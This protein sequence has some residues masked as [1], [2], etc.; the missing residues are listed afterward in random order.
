MD[1]IRAFFEYGGR[2]VQMPVNP[3]EF[4][5]EGEVDNETIDL[6]N[7]G[8]SVLLGN[9]KLRVLDFESFFPRTSE[10]SYV[11]TKG[12]F[13]APQFY[14]SF[15]NKIIDS[16]EPA[17]FILTGSNINLLVAINQ[18]DIQWK[19][20]DED[21]HYILKMSEYKPLSI[22]TVNVAL[23]RPIQPTR[24]PSTAT[25]TT[26]GSSNKPVTVGCNALVNG[27]LHRD[28]YGAGPGQTRTNYKG[29]INFIK[30]GRKCPYHVTTPS[31]GW[32]GWVVESA[33]KV[34]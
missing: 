26:S 7:N 12:K 13:E 6:Y 18:F 15:F 21:L 33:V 25:K 11:L 3:E 2:V 1:E 20:G 22:K 31:G 5:V 16:K 14:E 23:P 28:S 17:R 19:A 30:K 10:G 24:P 29:K 4:K 32:Q 34:I 27:R 8:E 9:K